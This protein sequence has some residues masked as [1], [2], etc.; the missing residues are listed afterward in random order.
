MGMPFPTTRLADGNSAEIEIGDN[1]RLNG[2][3][4]H[5]Q[6][7]IVIE[8]NCV[9]ASGVN[10]IDSNGHE[11]NSYNRTIGRDIPADIII[12]ENVWIGLNVIILKNT[13]IGKNSVICAGSVVK[14]NY[15]ET[16]ILQGNPAKIVGNIKLNCHQNE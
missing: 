2:V 15:P 7:R 4:I 8:K 16:S 3:Y 11:V 12:G 14:G 6:K 13:I 10:V 9:I 5:A 1:C